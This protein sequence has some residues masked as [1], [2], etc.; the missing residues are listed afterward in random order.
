M[1]IKRWQRMAMLF[2]KP[3]FVAGATLCHIRRCRFCSDHNRRIFRSRL[4]TQ[5]MASLMSKQHHRPSVHP[6]D[7]SVHPLII[8]DTQDSP[9]N[10]L[11][12]QAHRKEAYGLS[13]IIK[14]LDRIED[15]LRS[16]TS[17]SPALKYQH[18][19]ANNNDGTFFKVVGSVLSKPMLRSEFNVLLCYCYSQS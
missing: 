16:P 11:H 7:P 9:P 19:Y 15:I 1:P 18:C 12:P 2:P 10:H 4:S 17:E 5:P 8:H 14:Y 3:F 6:E 13:D